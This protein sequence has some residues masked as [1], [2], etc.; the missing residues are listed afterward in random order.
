LPTAAGSSAEADSP[1]AIGSW[2]A[3]AISGAVVLVW[4]EEGLFVM[5][6]SVSTSLILLGVLAISCIRAE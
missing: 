2:P 5:F 1:I 3:N 6:K 4:Q